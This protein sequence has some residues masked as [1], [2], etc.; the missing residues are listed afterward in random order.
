MQHRLELINLSRQQNLQTLVENRT[1]YSLERCELNVFETYTESLEVPLTFND[2]VI[3]SMLRGRKVMTI[4]G[5]EKFNYLPGETVIVPQAQTM[6]IDFPDA[7]ATDPTQCIALAIDRQQIQQTL[8]YL[9]EFYPKADSSE[10]WALKEEGCHFANSQEIAYLINKAVRICS[11]RSIE[12]DILA[13]LTMKELLVR[14][15]QK[16]NLRSLVSSAGAYASSPLAFVIQYIKS[17][18]G[19]KIN[20]NMLSEK[21]CMSKSTF[22]RLFKREL[23]ISPNDYILKEK[24]KRAKQLLS[25]PRSKIAAVSYELGFSDANYFIRIF[26]KIV[27]ITP[28]TYQV[29]ICSACEFDF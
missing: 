26:K 20:M 22:Y 3:T 23:G 21:A 10:C 2:L 1:V 14:I 13:D 24:I 25:N 12:K 9:N 6:N 17:N 8:D 29:Q 4:P 15:M 7:T 27:G 28:G 19:E 11:E 5:L 18:L 16:Q